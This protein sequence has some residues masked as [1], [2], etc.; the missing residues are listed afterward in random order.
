M[1]CHLYVSF[2][3]FI[4]VTLYSFSV[5][6]S[7]VLSCTLS[8]YFI[9]TLLFEA[10]PYGGLRG[11]I[12]TECG[13]EMLSEKAF[14]CDSDNATYPNTQ[15]ATMGSPALLYT[16]NKPNGEE[17]EPRKEEEKITSEN[18]QLNLPRQDQ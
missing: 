2:G 5:R 9:I 15:E 12:S 17:G 11:P 4:V 6:P 7:F 3:V 13:I 8:Q 14:G 1:E 18:N 10:A 16:S